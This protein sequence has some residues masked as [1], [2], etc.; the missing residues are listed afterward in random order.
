MT[1]YMLVYHRPEQAAAKL[2][3]EEMQRLMKRWQDWIAEGME[4]G[5]LVRRGDGKSVSMGNRCQFILFGEN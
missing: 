4:K 1:K 2:P 3:A 5:W